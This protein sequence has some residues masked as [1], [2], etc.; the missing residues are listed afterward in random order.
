MT[1]GLSDAYPGGDVRFSMFGSIADTEPRTVTLADLRMFV[2][3]GL[4]AEL[5]DRIRAEPDKTQRSKLKRGLPCVTVSGEFSGGRKAEHL[6]RH[7]GLICVDFDADDNPGMV[8]HAGE[9]RDRLVKDDA[10]MLAFVSASGNGVAAFCRIEPERHAEAF[11]ALCEHFHIC[12]GLAADRSCSDVSR[13]RFLSHDP[14]VAENP[15]PRVFR[16][17]KLAVQ[18][19]QPER[20]RRPGLLC[21]AAPALPKERREEILSALERVSPDERQVWLEVGMAIHSEAPG[22][23]GYNLWRVW[24]E[25]NDTAAKFNESDLE[26]VWL[27]FGQRSGIGIGTLFK[28]A[29]NAG[30]A[31]MMKGAGSPAPP[32]DGLTAAYGLPLVGDGEKLVINQ[33]RFAAQYV[34]SSGV[35]HDP[36]LK[37]FYVYEEDTG[38]WRHQSDDATL[39]RLS[40][41]FAKLLNEEGAEELLR[42]RSASM[43]KGLR[44]LARGIAE[45]RDVFAKRPAAIHVANG[46]L[47]I[48]DEGA[49]TLEPFG[50]QWYSRNRSEIRW[51][52]DA[53]CPRFKRELLL[54]AMDGDDAALIQRY[55]GQC[56]LGFNRSQTFLVLRGTAGGG[57]STLANVIE[58]V[59]GRHNVSELRVMQLNE[60]FELVRFVGRTLLSGKDVPGDF[61]NSKPAHVIK[62]LVGGDTLEGEA[63]HGNESF[64]VPGIFNVMIS[65]NTRLRVKLDSDAGAWRRRMLIV[66]YARPK[67][68]RPVPGFDALLLRE[69]GEGILRWAVEGAVRLMQELRAFGVIRLT[70]AQSRRVDDLLS[71]SDSVRSFVRECVVA[72]HGGEVTIQDLAAAYRDYCEARDWEPLRERQFQAELPDAMLDFHRAGRRNDI[73]AGGKAARGF[74]GVRLQPYGGGAGGSAVGAGPDASDG[75]REVDAGEADLFDGASPIE[76]GFSDGSDGLFK[77]NA[78]ENENSDVITSGE[79]SEASAPEEVPF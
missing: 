60:R 9:W 1:S 24:S 18:P 76:G 53:D 8:G 37:R 14:C 56:L 57:K 50:P 7:S 4:C 73:R 40:E 17:Y 26:R 16:N 5:V 20:E 69:E 10:V 70:E 75:L 33:M 30:W 63:K 2:S 42:S 52:P 46:M 59:I 79:P 31:G 48:G 39:E 68:A 3:E 77:V 49:V 51:N 32:S 71:E 55:A 72:C 62:A 35:V 23:E 19:P 44:E 45:A 38:L 36:T 47:V 25:F 13:L 43:L 21:A 27:S 58:G 34:R 12:Y 41:T 11:N 74:K 54:S 28:L 65:T 64:A 15:S 29:Y 22:L 67:V 66:D 78:Y 61:L 6:V